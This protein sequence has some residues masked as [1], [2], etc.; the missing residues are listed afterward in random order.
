MRTV[1]YENVTECKAVTKAVVC[2]KCK[3]EIHKKIDGVTFLQ[4]GTAEITFGYCSEHD[5]ISGKLVFDICDDCWRK[6]VNTFKIKPEHV[7]E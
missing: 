5:L 4:G 7:G 6:F 1:K 3:K 2:N